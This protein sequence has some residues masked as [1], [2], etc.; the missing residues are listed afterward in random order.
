MFM[1]YIDL[2]N[3]VEQDGELISSSNV[4]TNRSFE[5]KELTNVQIKFDDFRQLLISDDEVM[6]YEKELQWY[7]DSYNRPK[8]SP[9]ELSHEKWEKNPTF[10]ADTFVADLR[11]MASDVIGC[12][13]RCGPNSNYGSMCLRLE[14]HIGVT[15]FEWCVEK[16]KKDSSSRQAVAFYNSPNYQY[17]SN[18]DFVCCLTQMFNIKDNKLNTVINSR[19]ND[20]INSF[21][22]DM[23]WWRIF[24]KMIYNELKKTYPSLEM[25]YLFVNIFSAHYYLKDAYKLEILKKCDKENTFKSVSEEYL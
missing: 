2:L 5:T 12:C 10:K 1:T 25:G 20:L 4:S 7:L 14:N 17:W 22:F 16:L 24:Q 21:R 6:Y 15:Q 8:D 9:I 19:S 13:N 11:R 3:A 23:I 18:T